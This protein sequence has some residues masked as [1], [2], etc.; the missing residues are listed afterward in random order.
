MTSIWSI[1]CSNLTA[2]FHPL[3][4]MN[5]SDRSTSN[6]T[7]RE[8]SFNAHQKSTHL[9]WTEAFRSRLQHIKDLQHSPLVPTVLIFTRV[10]MSFFVLQLEHKLL[11]F[12]SFSKIMRRLTT[13]MNYDESP[14]KETSLLLPKGRMM[15]WELST[16]LQ[17]CPLLTIRSW[18]F[19]VAARESRRSWLV[20]SP[21]V[22]EIWMSKDSGVDICDSVE[23]S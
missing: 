17:R 6:E 5:P 21:A 3:P 11:M 22:G 23:C 12:A 10:L 8:S 7:S 2:G 16:R 4:R 15:I 1:F 18:R 14:Q 13:W 20:W 19:L 9:E